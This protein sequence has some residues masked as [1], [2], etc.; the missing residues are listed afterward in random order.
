LSHKVRDK[1]LVYS[2]QKT[3]DGKFIVFSF[4]NLKVYKDLLNFTKNIYKLTKLFPKDELFGLTS[5]L[6]RA[7]S[8]VVLNIAEGSSL[9]KSEFKNFLRRAR[10]SVYECVPIL[11]IALDTQYISKEEYKK[12]YES[13]NILARS[14]SALINSMK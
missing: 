12:M 10:G 8:S 2:S 7:S 13:C 5:Q 11:A 4:E 9:T 1:F 3:E 14:I 6:R